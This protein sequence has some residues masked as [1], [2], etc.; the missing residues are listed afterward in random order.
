MKITRLFTQTK[1]YYHFHLIGTGMIINY[2]VN[3]KQIVITS[4]ATGAI[5]NTFDRSN[6]PNYSVVQFYAE[7]KGF[8]KMFIEDDEAQTLELSY[9]KNPSHIGSAGVEV[10]FELLSN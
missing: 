2:I 6:D 4:V 5:I 9:L 1:G 10:N 8:Y 3:T 7:A